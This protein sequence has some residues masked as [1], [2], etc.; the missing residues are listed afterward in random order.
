M[1]S[2]SNPP[3]VEIDAGNNQISR[4]DACASPGNSQTLTVRQDNQN[5]SQRTRR[6]W[7][8][9]SVL[10]TASIAALISPVYHLAT[11]L[12][13]APA[14]LDP[15]DYLGRARQILKTTPLIDGHNDL[16][17]MLRV[18]LQNKI[19]EGV[20]LSEK[21]LGHTDLYRMREGQVGGQF[22][23]VWVDCEPTD[24]AEDPTVSF[25]VSYSNKKLG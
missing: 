6:L 9:P 14:P 18:E 24:Y 17:Y 7:H 1:A 15:T 3:N 21:L 12:V 10:I 2:T 13:P 8:W 19:Y 22:W 23:S 5:G 25:L 11:S 20:N 16:P 4:Q